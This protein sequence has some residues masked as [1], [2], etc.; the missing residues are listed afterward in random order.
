MHV[1]VMLALLAASTSAQL[2]DPIAHDGNMRNTASNKY[3][4]R[5]AVDD[6]EDD[7]AMCAT[8]PASPASVH[9]CRTTTSRAMHTDTRD[10]RCQCGQHHPHQSDR[11]GQQTCLGGNQ[12]GLITAYVI[13]VA[14]GSEVDGG[15]EPQPPI[16]KLSSASGA[17]AGRRR[18]RWTGERSRAHR[19][20]SC[21][22]SASWNP[23]Y[24]PP[25]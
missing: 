18:S 24:T 11:D 25:R 12:R 8:H 20:W 9:L 15:G 10:G 22:G 1:L 16:P 4:A 3:L 6:T 14:R 17:P 21:G 2:S 19:I 13:C 5:S 23:V 7:G